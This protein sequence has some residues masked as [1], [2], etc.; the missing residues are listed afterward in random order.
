MKTRNGFVSNSS[1]T[2]FIITNTSDK[3]KTI[4]DFAKENIHLL[5]EFKE[6]YDYTSWE[7]YNEKNFLKGAKTYPATFE[8]GESKECVFGDEDGTVIGTVFD[9]MLRY[10][11]ESKSFKWKFHEMM[12]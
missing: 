2:S 9:Y 12:R 4:L 10:G 8:P 3:E 11:G 5:Q 1:S 6:K 7:N